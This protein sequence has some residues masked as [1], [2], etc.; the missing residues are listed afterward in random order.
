[1]LLRSG[2]GCGSPPMNLIPSQIKEKDSR[3]ILAFGDATVVLPSQ[4][5]DQAKQIKKQQVLLGIR[6]E[7]IMLR[8]EAS[9]QTLSGTV[10]A[11]EPLGREALLHISTKCCNILVLTPEKDL[12][13]DE[14]V[15]VCFDPNRVHLF[16]CR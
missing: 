14:R 9:G 2:E 13:T 7:H 16:G 4:K 11:I 10:T 5:A 1:M 6:P 8:S 3:I 15:F 12:R